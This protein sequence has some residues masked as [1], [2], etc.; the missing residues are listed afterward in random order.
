MH[1]DV[2]RKSRTPRRRVQLFPFSSNVA[3]R[4]ERLA[5]SLGAQPAIVRGLLILAV[6][7]E[8]SGQCADGG[9][10]K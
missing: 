5:L 10:G 9:V 1:Y 4:E 3:L 6:R 8:V 7:R 2:P